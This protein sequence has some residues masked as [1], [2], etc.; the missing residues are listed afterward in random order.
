MAKTIVFCADGTWNGPEKNTGVSPVDD[1][2]E[3]GELTQANITN[4][5]KLFGNLAGDATPET[6]GLQKEQEKVLRNADGSV[7]QVAKYLH[8]VGD[9]ANL[10]IKLLGG[11][12]GVGVISRIVRGYTFIS[13]NYAPGDEI[14][15]TGFSRGA[16]TARALAGM[17][18][19][20]G[21]LNPKS[22]NA[23]DKSEAYRY[24]LAAWCKSKGVTLAGDDKG[25]GPAAWLINTAQGLLAKQLR[26]GDLIPD[27][28]IKSVAVWD[29][30][31]SLGIPLYAMG[32]RNDLFRFT[33]SALSPKVKNGF[34]AMSIDELRIDFPVTRWDE[35]D[36]VHQVWFAG[37]HA[38]VG[39]GYPQTEAGLSDFALDW[40]MQQLE[41][42]GVR[43][44]AQLAYNPS[45]QRPDQSIHEP[46]TKPP[47]ALL[48]RSPRKILPG[49][50]VHESAIARW[51]K[52][53]AYRPQAMLA[54]GEQNIVPG[55]RDP[56]ETA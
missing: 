22:Y 50:L 5:V 31:G 37:A 29:T 30:V 23:A 52:S 26:D 36:G 12:L 14:H 32:A 17:I 19:K 42:A 18:A 44:T 41:R 2:D 4:V 20:V 47:F 1:S 35:R 48:E 24:G 3:H 6:R 55:E 38:D 10:L 9:S 27:V 8:G 45:P 43:F 51:R 11:T 40:M 53:E 25:T 28:D 13:R 34:H 39:G 16:Y 33:D 56:H 15:I 7:A 21:L 46:W 54:W 49:D